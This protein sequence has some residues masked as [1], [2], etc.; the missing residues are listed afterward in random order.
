MRNLIAIFLLTIIS[1]STKDKAATHL[2]TDTNQTELASEDGAVFNGP[3]VFEKKDE[4]KN[5]FPFN[6]SDKVEL[7][8]YQCR[9]DSYSND[10]LISNDKFSVAN[11]KQRVSLG[12]S[13][14]DSV[15]SLLYNYKPLPV[16]LDTL[17]ADCYNPRHSIVFYEKSKAI[18][19]FEI[20]FEC[21]GTR[22]SKGVDFGQFCPE[23]MCMLQTFFKT[24]GADFGVID[25]MCE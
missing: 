21:G 17:Q 16:G 14:R 12:K 20:C 10:N 9:R 8:S 4:M 3:C 7:V 19:F 11:I 6:V 23:K 25:E 22:Q 2:S 1:C 24:S 13:Q 5:T 18:A 15:F